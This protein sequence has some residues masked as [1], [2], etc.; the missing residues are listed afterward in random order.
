MSAAIRGK[1]VVVGDTGVGKTA[2]VVKYKT[3]DL[4][5]TEATIGANSI[6][7]DV[8]FADDKIIKLNVWD[9]AG[10]DD[11][12][13]LLPMYTRGAEVAVIV[14]DVT[15]RPTFNHVE[16]WVSFFQEEG[17]TCKIIVACN[18][19]DLPN[20]AVDISEVE[21]FCEGKGIQ[22]FS[23]SAKSGDGI[24]YLF[25]AI[26]DIVNKNETN[27]PKT[28]VV[29]FTH[30]AMVNLKGQKKNGSCC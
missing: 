20:H 26:A 17:N 1:V 7:C 8:K 22:Y 15:R 11:F 21:A 23:T 24:D 5:E 27:V 4:E 2:L 9:T 16:D 19:N 10:Q 3:G 6:Q 30:P 25:F 18:K 14:F 28:K 29:N 13:C 12:K